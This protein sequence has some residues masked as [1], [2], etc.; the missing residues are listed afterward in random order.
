MT[1]VKRARGFESDATAGCSESSSRVLRV[2]HLTPAYFSSES[3][4]GGGERYVDYIVQALRG[5]G[6]F[7]QCIFSLGAEDRL[8]EREGIPIRILHDESSL[9]GQ[10]DGFSSALWQELAG[11]D[12]VHLHQCL[13]G[14]GAYCTTIVRSLGI[15]SIGTDLGGAENPLMLGGR[16]IELLNG[17]VSISEYAYS[18]L[19]RY[20]SGPHEVLVGP[21][22]TDRF[23]VASV[24]RRNRQ[25][26]L[27]VSRIMPH[28][29]IDRVIAALP[30]Q[31]SL[32]IVG[33]V[34]HEPYYE[35][36]RQMSNGRDIR[37]VLDADDKTLLAMYQTAGVFVQ[38]STARDVYGN[39][40]AKSELMGLTT[41]EAMACG[42]PVVVSDTGSLPEL[43]PDIRF[44]RTFSDEEELGAI[45]RSVSSGAWPD[46]SAGELARAHV[47]EAHGMRAI[48][49]RL[50]TF[51]RD[52][53]TAHGKLSV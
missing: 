2:A 40:V 26:V 44:G 13:T 35:L 53:V 7:E 27:C 11:F 28:K 52:V 48:A 15:P 39:R 1:F 42:L 25:M 30:R 31:M 38:A 22:D 34:Y 17:I 50:A 21:V 51:Y 33:R 49:R 29:G 47:V 10:T 46:A 12:L 41:L 43:V 20:F 16:G 32:T 6:G 3:Y 24:V 36:L 4:V 18:L 5:I 14:F 23:S 9:P 8:V 37:F 45:L 19:C